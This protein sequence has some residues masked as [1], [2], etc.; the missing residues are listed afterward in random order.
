MSF[1]RICSTIF[2]LIVADSGWAQEPALGEFSDHDADRLVDLP[3][4]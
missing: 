3:R 1:A 4:L 2:G